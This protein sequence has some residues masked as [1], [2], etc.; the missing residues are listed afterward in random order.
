MKFKIT[1]AIPDDIADL[2]LAEVAPEIG[3]AVHKLQTAQGALADVKARCVT[4]SETVE[5]V[6]REIAAGIA[7]P[8]DL[9]AAIDQQRVSALS[10]A[11]HVQQVG[12]AE[13]AL[14]R[15]RVQARERFRDEVMTRHATLMH[16]ARE[17]TPLLERLREAEAELDAVIKRETAH[18]SALGVPQQLPPT[19]AL[20]WPSSLADECGRQALPHVSAPMPVPVPPQA[21]VR[22]TD[23]MDTVRQRNPPAAAPP[24]QAQE[25]EYDRRTFGVNDWPPIETQ[26]RA[27]NRQVIS[28]DALRPRRQQLL[29]QC[30][31]LMKAG[32]TDDT[33]TTFDQA[34][35][36]I[37]EI[38]RQ[39]AASA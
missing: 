22:T 39:V 15:V 31:Q 35:R 11:G 21:A 17:V 34:M 12:A 1:A 36:E 33:R 24:A 4:N 8:S 19:P 32:F 20:E 3:R 28:R 18:T 23:Y 26:A 9:Q 2:T 25:P 7:R 29:R 30:D 37:E 13:Q 14:E 27:L 6:R 16:V 38:D 10:V 5:R